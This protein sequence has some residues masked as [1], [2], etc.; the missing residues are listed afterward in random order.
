[1]FLKR[2]QG[3]LLKL[4]FGHDDT[5]E[6]KNHAEKGRKAAIKYFS[7]LNW[8]HDGNNQQYQLYYEVNAENKKSV[9]DQVTRFLMRGFNIV[10]YQLTAFENL[11]NQKM[12]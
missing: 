12:K 8:V 6:E 9:Q 7:S 10:E 1:M 5:P 3:F 2:T 11:I 4:S